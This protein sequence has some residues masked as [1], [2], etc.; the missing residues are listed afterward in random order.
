MIFGHARIRAAG[1]AGG[2]MAQ[3]AIWSGTGSDQRIVIRE[4]GRAVALDT[5]PTPDNRI[6][7]EFDLVS[8]GDALAASLATAIEAKADLSSGQYQ[9]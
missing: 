7:G 2:N 5:G 3:V 1:T 4:V 9:K 8:S 6:I